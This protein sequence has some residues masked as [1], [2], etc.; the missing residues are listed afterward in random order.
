MFPSSNGSL[1][2]AQALS[3]RCSPSLRVSSPAVPMAWMTHNPP[4]TDRWSG[5]TLTSPF[6]S[7]PSPVFPLSHT[8][9]S[10][11]YM[12]LAS[13]LSLSLTRA[14]HARSPSSPLPLLVSTLASP[15]WAHYLL[16]TRLRLCCLLR[17]HRH[18]FAPAPLSS[19]PSLYSPLSLSRAR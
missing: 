15:A 19:K 12:A 13:P 11:T 8:A 18:G 1:T 3:R 2:L 17:W 9:L 16:S 7:A 5:T 6:L 14:L 10:R 4:L